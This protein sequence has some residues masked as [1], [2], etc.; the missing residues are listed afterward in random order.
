MD[1]MDNKEYEGKEC[2]MEKKKM[3][4]ILVRAQRKNRESKRERERE[5]EKEEGLR[6]MNGV[7]KVERLHRGK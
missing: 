6:E 4:E 3:K 5:R 1:A 2:W 7:N